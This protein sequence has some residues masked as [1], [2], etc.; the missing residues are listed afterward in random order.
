M[1]E[2][3]DIPDIWNPK[4]GAVY[5]N[6]DLPHC[7]ECALPGYVKSFLFIGAPVRCSACRRL[8]LSAI[9]EQSSARVRGERH[10]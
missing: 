3:V 4:A 1:P 2:P 9:E 8:I 6:G 5:W 10:G 7:E